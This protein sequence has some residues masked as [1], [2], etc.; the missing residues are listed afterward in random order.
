MN[1]GDTIYRLRTEKNMSQ[2][3]LADALGVSRQS[4]SKW[5]NGNATPDLDK[6]IKM[7]EL[8]GITLD[9]LVGRDAPYQ[10]ETFTSSPITETVPRISVQKIVGIILL[11]TGFVFLSFSLSAE[12]SS[13][14]ISQLLFAVLFV[15]CGTICLKINKH[16]G[17]VCA[18]VL[19]LFTWFPA[20]VLSP[21]YI[22]LDFARVIQLIHILWGV[23]LGSHGNCVS[24][25][26]HLLQK[27]VE[28]FLFLAILI[29]T[30]LISFISLLFPGLL[31]TPGLL[32]L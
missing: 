4:V 23:S 18:C 25:I 27:H 3:D 20:G 24:K 7:S 22:R 30:V 8:F 11:C 29:L 19:Y 2:G 28:K 5:E 13:V 21:N 26:G 14:L 32:V 17:F 16:A 10:P 6:L 15:I 12:N 1:L 31:P 9:E